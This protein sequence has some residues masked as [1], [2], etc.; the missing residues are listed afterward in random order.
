M[1]AFY[2]VLGATSCLIEKLRKVNSRIILILQFAVS[3]MRTSTRYENRTRDSTVKGLRLNHLPKR[4]D[5]R[6]PET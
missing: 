5:V 3:L 6:L 1:S 4:T 2:P